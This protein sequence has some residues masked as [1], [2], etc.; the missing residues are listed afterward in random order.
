MENL[1]DLAPSAGYYTIQQLDT[2]QSS[3]NIIVATNPEQNQSYKKGKIIGVGGSETTDS[4][5]IIKPEYSIDD[6]VW[7]GLSSIKFEEITENGKSIQLI[8]FKSV[9]ALADHE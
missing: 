9:V 3:S 1:L 2:E 5:A 8:R 7:Y 6:I 4:G